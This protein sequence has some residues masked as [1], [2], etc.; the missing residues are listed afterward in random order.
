M[1]LVSEMA[2][3]PQGSAGTGVH[4]PPRLPAARHSRFGALGA[5]A[6][7]ASTITMDARG[8]VAE[9]RAPAAEFRVIPCRVMERPP[10]SSPLFGA[11]PTAASTVRRSRLRSCLRRSTGMAGGRRLGLRARAR[12]AEQHGLLREGRDPDGAHGD[13]PARQARAIQARRGLARRLNPC[14]RIWSSPTSSA[15]PGPPTGRPMPGA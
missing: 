12:Q 6:L 5:A 3:A 9:G 14:A 13:E 2:R 1:R 15:L 8:P 7:P 11:V 10:G 4:G